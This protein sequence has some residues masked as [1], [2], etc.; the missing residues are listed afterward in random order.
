MSRIY[1]DSLVM[2]LSWKSRVRFIDWME[3][4]EL[5]V[6]LKAPLLTAYLLQGGQVY[7]RAT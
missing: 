4:K 1:I 6:G 2:S 3:V 7:N 5:Q